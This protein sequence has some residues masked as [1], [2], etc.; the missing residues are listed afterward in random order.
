MPY[1]DRQL[2][3][4]F[5]RCLMCPRCWQHRDKL[6]AVLVLER[7]MS[8]WQEADVQIRAVWCRGLSPGP[9]A[10]KSRCKYHL[11]KTPAGCS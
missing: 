5:I 9:G 10:A 8:P 2:I 11:A 1:C 3:M 6:H 4:S 7:P